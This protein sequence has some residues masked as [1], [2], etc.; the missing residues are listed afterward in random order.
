MKPNNLRHNNQCEACAHKQN[1]DGGHCYM[2]RSEPDEPCCQH[3][4][5]VLKAM[6]SRMYAAQRH[7]ASIGAAI[8][9]AT[10]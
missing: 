1:P 7:F 3:S 8:G 6:H 4:V 9:G 2:F 10:P 5:P